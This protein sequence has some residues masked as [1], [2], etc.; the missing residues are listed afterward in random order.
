MA[1][2]ASACSSSDSPQ[3]SSPTVN[4]PPSVSGAP[5]ASAVQD[6]QYSF[7]PTSSDPNGDVLTF[8]IT[9]MPSWASF[10]AT[11]GALSGTP[12]VQHLGTYANILI[13]VSDG[14]DS[15]ELP[16]F[17]IE[18]VPTGSGSLSITWSPPTES[19]DGSSLNDLAGYR[20]HWGTQSGSHPNVLEVNNP[21]LSRYVIDGLV[22]GNYFF[23]ISAVDTSSNESKASNEASGAVQ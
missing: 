16:A 21:S 22:S 20:I 8:T 23:I 18:V 17:D 5:P 12:S 13:S 19:A 10:D 6:W 14:Q 11:S 1:L 4:Q 15:V 7:T 9:N 2:A 3:L